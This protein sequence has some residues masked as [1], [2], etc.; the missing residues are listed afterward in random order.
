M[1]DE[2][3]RYR[4]RFAPAGSGSVFPRSSARPSRRNSCSHALSQPLWECH[5]AV[6]LWCFCPGVTG[7]MVSYW[8]QHGDP[9]TRQTPCTIRQSKGPC[10]ATV[11]D[12]ILRSSA[13][14]QHRRPGRKSHRACIEHASGCIG[15]RRRHSMGVSGCIRASIEVHRPMQNNH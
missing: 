12:S 5:C 3:D 15:H 6:G 7:R 2:F 13:H 8:P 11:L 4:S 1:R 9:W 14:S 10:I